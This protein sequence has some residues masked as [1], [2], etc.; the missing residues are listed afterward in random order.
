MQNEN[1]KP[2]PKCLSLLG[3][4]SKRDNFLLF[5]VL[6]SVTS[7]FGSFLGKMIF[8]M[9]IFLS[10][11]FKSLI[12]LTTFISMRFSFVPS[13][14][15]LRKGSKLA[16]IAK[17]SGIWIMNGLNVT[18]QFV[19]SGT[20]KITQFTIKANLNFVNFKSMIV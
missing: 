10:R 6:F 17:I 9:L 11:S 1:S 2:S 3:A 18:L 20:G 8:F 19:F 13:Q 7:S 14:F 4:L 5:L 12:T 15:C 16:N